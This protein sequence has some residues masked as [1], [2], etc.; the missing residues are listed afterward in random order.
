MTHSESSKGLLKRLKHST[1]AYGFV[2]PFF[3][4]SIT[5]GIIPIFQVVVLS[6]QTG[7]FLGARDWAGWQ[8]YVEV[9]LEPENLQSFLNNLT[10]LIMMVPIGQLL[11]FSIAVPL[12]DKTRFSALF[13]TIVFLPLLISM[14]AAGIVI[15]Y[16]FGSRGPVNYLL[17]SVGIGE[18]NWLGDPFRAKVVISV[19]EIWKGATFYTFIYI[20]ALRSIPDAFFEAADIEGAGWLRKLWMITLPLIR[21][22]I[23][24]CVIMTSIWNLQIFDSIYVTTKGGPLNATSSVVFQIYQTTFKHNEVGTGAAL[25]IVFLIF[26][27]I[28]TALQLRFANTDVEY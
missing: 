6:F 3:L 23:F 24:F 21:H 12:R 2:F 1:V 9:F 14:V 8:S 11:A 4:F 17:R 20:A 10:Y 18:L 27:L 19:L 26:I 7:G 16:I 15:L 13:E 5:F 25:S 22:T 28:F